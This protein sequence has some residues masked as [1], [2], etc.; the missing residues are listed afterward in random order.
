M[1]RKTQQIEMHPAVWEL[2]EKYLVVINHKINKRGLPK[3][4]KAKLLGALLTHT[5]LPHRE[6]V[7]SKHEETQ[8]NTLLHSVTKCGGLGA[9]IPGF[10]E[11]SHPSGDGRPPGSSP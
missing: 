1:E 6:H 7:L 2:L 5:L 10:S 11:V 3:V 4:T 9:E 8:L